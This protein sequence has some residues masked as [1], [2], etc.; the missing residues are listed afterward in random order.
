MGEHTSV[1]DGTH[2]VHSYKLQGP[3]WCYWGVWA[4]QVEGPA[5]GQ[6]TKMMQHLCLLV[7]LKQRWVGWRGRVRE[8]ER[9]SE[10]ESE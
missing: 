2:Q 4:S 8:S 1:C 3:T 7:F 6:L 5:A 9:A 10:G